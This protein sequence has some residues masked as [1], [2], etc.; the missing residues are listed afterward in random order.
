MDSCDFHSSD[1]CTIRNNQSLLQQLGT[2]RNPLG[3][4]GSLNHLDE[5]LLDR[6]SGKY[7]YSAH[8][9]NL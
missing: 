5:M 3:V 4:N 2:N 1:D 7:P 6:F 8:P 9:R